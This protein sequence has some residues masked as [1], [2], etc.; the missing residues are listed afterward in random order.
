[1][2]TLRKFQNSINIFYF[3]T[4]FS[5]SFPSRFVLVAPAVLFLSSQ[6]NTVNPQSLTIFNIN[7]FTVCKFF[8]QVSHLMTKPTKWHV[9]P[10][11]TQISLGIRPVWSVFPVPQWV[12]KDP[13]F[14]HANSEDSDQPGWMPRLIWVFAECTC[15]FVC[16]VMSQVKF[17]FQYTISVLFLLILC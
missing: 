2:N 6:G 1:M 4:S 12:A 8:Y 14:L 3:N 5:V 10:V 7:E 17:L 11:K 13:G 15:H 16:F 9:C